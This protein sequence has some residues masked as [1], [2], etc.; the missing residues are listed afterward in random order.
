MQ[1]EELPEC[2]QTDEPFEVEV[3]VEGTEGRGQRKRN[4]VVYND[5]LSDDQWALAL[6]DGEDLDEFAV[7]SRDKKDKRA[8]NKLLK[9]AEA[10]GRGTPISDTD[11]RGRK[12]KKGKSKMNAPDYEPSPANGKRKRGMKSLSVTPSVND[13]DDD[14]RDSKR[15]KTKA[16]ELPPVI[17]DKM[18]KAFLE[19]HKA[20]MACED[21]T[22]RRRCEL[23]KDLPD[24]RDYP[25][26]YQLI[27]QPIALSHIRKRTN[28]NVYKTVTAYRADWRLMFGNARTYNQEGSWVYIDA[29]EMEKV[30]EA[31]FQRHVANA[32]FPGSS[33]GDV[34]SGS[35]AYDAMDDDEPLPPPR[36]KSANRKAVIS[37]DD[38]SSDD[39]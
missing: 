16:A 34:A 3:I 4:T 15:R 8:T 18:K 14:D 2:Y 38:Y 37:D 19:C 29:E 9:D 10:S 35:G 39:D 33:G 7:R 24:R 23:F 17:R 1:L 20:V 12:S 26:Y 28:S 6:E 32:G 30:F 27:K 5:G 11:S 36:S 21:D 13:D 31:A 22:G 25:D